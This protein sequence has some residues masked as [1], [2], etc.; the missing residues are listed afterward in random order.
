M[1]LEDVGVSTRRWQK[2]LANEEPLA[3]LDRIAR[4]MVHRSRV[5]RECVVREL[6]E[7]PG[8]TVNYQAT[9]TRRERVRAQ[10]AFLQWADANPALTA[11]ARGI[12]PAIRTVEVV[13]VSPVSLEELEPDG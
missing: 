5:V 6:T 2:W 13:E 3:R 7:F 8:L 10:T 1:T 12:R 4:A 9:A 11:R